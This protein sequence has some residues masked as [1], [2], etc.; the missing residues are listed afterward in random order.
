VL[1]EAEKRELREM[2]AS[3]TLREEFQTLQRNSRNREANISVDDLMRW[4]TAMGQ[5]CPR[6]ASSRPFIHYRHVKI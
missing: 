6:L 4:L 3:T 5:I 1:T 2:A